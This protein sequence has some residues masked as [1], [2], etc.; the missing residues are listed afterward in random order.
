MWYVVLD[1]GQ[2]AEETTGFETQEAELGSE[3]SYIFKKREGS[4]IIFERLQFFVSFSSFCFH[5]S[6]GPS[7]NRSSI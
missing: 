1:Y 2:V 4:Y 7:F 5:R 3:R 6:R